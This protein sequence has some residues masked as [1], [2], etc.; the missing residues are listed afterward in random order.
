MAETEIYGQATETGSGISFLEETWIVPCSDRS[1]SVSIEADVEEFE[2]PY[3]GEFLEVIGTCKTA[4]T[5][6]S[7]II[8]IHLAGTTIMATDKI[9]IDVTERSSLDAGTQP[10]L[11]TTTF[12]KGE[13]ISIDLDQVGTTEGGVAV[14]AS[15][16][17]K[18]TA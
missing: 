7:L 13:I 5:G 8:D 15:I 17:V 1:T 18:R 3:D 11:T 16:R 10:A 12:S 14:K 4:P 2:A 6:A 9:E